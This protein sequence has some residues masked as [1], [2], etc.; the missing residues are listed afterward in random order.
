[1]RLPGRRHE[2]SAVAGVRRPLAPPLGHER[3][4]PLLP[5]DT[6]YGRVLLLR[7]VRLRWWLRALYLEGAIVAGFVLYLA[8]WASAWVMVALPAAIGVAVKVYDLA[9]VA[10]P[11][12]APG[13]RGPG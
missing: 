4:L 10:G 3:P 6:L 5:G 8:D 1:M 11:G 2:G 9:L 12:Q 7:R 13:G